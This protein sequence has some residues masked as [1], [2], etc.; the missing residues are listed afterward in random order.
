MSSRRVSSPFQ[1]HHPLGLL[2]VDEALG[3]VPRGG[4]YFF[5]DE[6]GDQLLFLVGLLAAELVGSVGDLVCISN[7]H[8][9]H[10]FKHV[11]TILSTLILAYLHFKLISLHSQV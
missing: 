10:S 4:E 2:V 3:E 11:L 8:H 7:I 9:S 5:L 1:H 6:P